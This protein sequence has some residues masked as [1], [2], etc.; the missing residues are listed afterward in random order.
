MTSTILRAFP[1]NAA[2]FTV[3][4]WVFRALG[5]PQTPVEAKAPVIPCVQPAPAIEA[6]GVKPRQQ[7]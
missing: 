6:V 2:T 7:R 3:V 4:G 1:T 5:S